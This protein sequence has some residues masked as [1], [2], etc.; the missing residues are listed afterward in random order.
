MPGRRGLFVVFEGGEGAG[1]ST[2]VAMLAESLG[3]RGWD[4]VRTREP[5]GTPTAEA[6]RRVLLEVTDQPMAGRCEVLLFAAARADHAAAVIRPA[7]ERGA[8]VLC[9]RYIDSSLAYQGA[10]RGFGVADVGAI[11]SWATEGLVPDLTVLLD[12]D[13]QL[14]LSRAQDGNRMEEE[15]LRFHEEVRQEFR[16]LADREPQRYLVVAA[17]R[18][19]EDIAGHVL[20]AVDLIVKN[21]QVDLS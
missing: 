21:T 11:S 9:D 6:I 14:G 18:P 19:V 17:D 1:K 4:V 3:A 5:G 16:N 2:Q 10:A 15:S 12:V 7:L 20:A 13:P 8:V